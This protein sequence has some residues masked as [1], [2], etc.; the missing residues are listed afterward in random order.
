MLWGDVGMW[1][2]GGGCGWNN[3]GENVR[4]CGDGHGVSRGVRYSVQ[5]VRD[6][7]FLVKCEYTTT[8]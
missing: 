6:V 8:I 1:G 2:C 3:E 7:F 5:L 4:W